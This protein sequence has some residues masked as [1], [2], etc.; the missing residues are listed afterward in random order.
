MQLY[1]ADEQLHQQHQ[2][3]SQ[4]ARFITRALAHRPVDYKPFAAEIEHTIIH[5]LLAHGYSVTRAGA[6]AHYDLLVNGL[7]V[8]VKAAAYTDRY[9]AALRSNDADVLILCCRSPRPLGEGLGVRGDDV[10]DHYFV[11]PFDE[12]RGRTNIKITSADPTAYTGRLRTWYEAWPLID[13]L[14]AAGVNHWQ[15]P[16]M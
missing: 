5:R 14:I 12:V 2:A 7:R 6:N 13:Q 16:L 3:D 11:I 10:T 15:L 4:R 8:E 9:Q 1:T